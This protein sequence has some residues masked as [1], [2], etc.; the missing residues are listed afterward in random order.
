MFSNEDANIPT[1]SLIFI[2]FLP[3]ITASGLNVTNPARKIPMRSIASPIL[4]M[5]FTKGESVHMRIPENNN[6][7]TAIRVN[8]IPIAVTFAISSFVLV[9]SPLNQLINPIT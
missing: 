4:P 9:S 8:A 3:K 7:G 1:E 5:N 6:R 2:M